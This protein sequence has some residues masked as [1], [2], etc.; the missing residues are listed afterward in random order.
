MDKGTRGGLI[1]DS[2][3]GV[4]RWLVLVRYL[5]VNNEIFEKLFTCDSPM[6][7]SN[8]E[9][10]PSSTCRLGGQ[11]LMILLNNVVVSLNCTL[12]VFCKISQVT[13]H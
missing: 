2:S 1:G 4:C 10:S 3:N 9:N 12:T 8:P 5:K 7:D 11:Y 13:H 6:Y